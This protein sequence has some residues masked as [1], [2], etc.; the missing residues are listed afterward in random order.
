MA[1]SD[2]TSYTDGGTI[3]GGSPQGSVFTDIVTPIDGTGS[4]ALTHAPSNEFQSINLVPA[5]LPKGFE[6]GRMRTLIRIDDLD[7]PSMQENH[8]GILFMQSQENMADFD[9]GGQSYGLSLSVGEGFSPQSFRLWK[10]TGGL[11]GGSGT[12]DTMQI[13]DSV[14]LPFTLTSGIV[15]GIEVEWRTEPEVISEIG[16]ALIICRAGE[17]TDFSDL[18]DLITFTDTTS[19]YTTTVAE[20]I[21]AGFKNQMASGNNRVTFDLT[22]LVEIILS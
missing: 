21:F 4:V 6:A 13:L 19:P 1:L 22:T 12:L 8:F 5:T 18:Q 16:G 2:W 11:N 10:F 17:E 20:G 7:D 14:A 15:V 3:G 9:G